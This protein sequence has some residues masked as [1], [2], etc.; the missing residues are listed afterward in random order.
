[1][2]LDRYATG[3]VR[4]ILG[5]ACETDTEASRIVH[6]AER[7]GIEPMQRFAQ[8]AGETETV[9]FERG[10]EAIGL[11]F[12]DAVPAGVELVQ[13]SGGVE[14]L[15]DIHSLRGRLVDREV[16]FA[17]PGFGRL[18]ELGRRVRRQPDLARQVCIV[19]PRR[20]A[21]HLAGVN[22]DDLMARA[23]ERLA[24]RWPHA[25]A[26]KE[27]TP[28]V[29]AGFALLMAAVVALA[30]LMPAVLVWL[31][32]P[33][34]AL[35]YLTPAVLRLTA[36]IVGLIDPVRERLD[37][38]DDDALPAYT[39]LVPL[40]DEAELVPQL[41]NALLAIDY[42]RDRLDIKFAVE[43]TSVNTLEA[44][45][46]ALDSGPFEL[47]VVPDGEPRTKPKALNFV[48]PLA[49]GEFL[50]IY[51]AED[52]PEPDQL[53]LAA[54]KFESH[55]EFDC[56]QAELVI[57]NAPESLLTALFTAEYAAQ[58]GLILPALA[59]F[60]L[61]MPLGGTSNHFRMRA[62]IEAGGWDSYNVTEDADLGVRLARLRYRCG[63]LVSA[64]YEEAPVTLIGWLKQRT[65]WMKGW[66][67]TLIVHNQSPRRLIAD[68]GV[69][70]FLA[71]E[72]YVGGQ[73]LTAPVHA[74]FVGLVSWRLASGGLAGAF[75]FDFWTASLAGVLVFGYASAIT[76]ALIGLK[77]FG[78]LKLGWAQ[79]LLPLYWILTSVAAARAAVQLVTHPF[80]WEKT[81]HART[82]L[83]R[84][85]FS[86]RI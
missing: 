51:D 20:L 4:H 48:L 33:L 7:A 44:L 79:V 86:A 63:T 59:R 66:M 74:L 26:H 69:W 39:I 71:F 22:G 31:I 5:A 21:G 83:E 34:L 36:S 2:P 54:A 52:V 25:S 8:V 23:L 32:A 38:L 55:P 24:R 73:V 68:M 75:G 40:R 10:A 62:L 56:L 13:G 37:L 14:K 28:R 76:A 46:P 35:A 84:R 11:A 77:R 6:D 72:V 61:P 43:A 9:I 27:L 30:V 82:R 80:V 41:V 47:I 65:R 16:L 12:V 18:V 42:P 50:V 78:R 19:P 17:A 85:R 15:G 58:F 67:Q 49:R 3:I 64:T 1:M 29:R 45:K 53:R 57:D 60:G 70:R 81:R